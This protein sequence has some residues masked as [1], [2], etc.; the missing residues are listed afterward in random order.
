MKAFF[1]SSTFK[2]MQSERDILHERVFPKLRKVVKEYGD[3]VQEVD[4]RWG[5]D[6]VNMTEE[7]S[8]HEVLKIC[9]DAIDRCKPYLIVLLGERYGWIPGKDVVDSA[10]DMRISDR[11]EKEMSITEL[12]IQYGALLNDEAFK[13][14]IFCFRDA[15]VID[16]IDQ[17]QRYKY[18]A[19]SEHHA[20][21]LKALKNQ[22]RSREGAV[23]LDYT[24]DWDSESG[25]IC[26]LESFE[27][28]LYLLLEDMIRKDFADKKQRSLK[29][30]QSDEVELIKHEYLS[31]YVRR[32]PEEFKLMRII[33]KFIW[34]REVESATKDADCVIVKGVAGS[35]KS[36]LMA[37]VS[38]ETDKQKNTD[39]ILCFA[40]TS[41]CRNAQMLKRYIAFKLEEILELEH[42]ETPGSIDEHLRALSRKV[43]RKTIVC[44]VDGLDQIYA[45]E[46]EPYIDLPALCP[47]IFWVFSALP[48]FPFEKAAS[49]YRHKQ[50]EVEGLYPEQRESI[51]AHT[52]GKRGK[53]LDSEVVGMIAGRRG[54]DNPL[55]IS[56]VLQRF[57]MMNKKEFEEAEALAPGMEGLHRHMQKMLAEMPDMPD[58][59][60]GYILE[61]TAGLFDQQ[62][63]SEILMLIA[64]SKSG[65]T[66]NEIADLL[67]LENIRFSQIAFQ[68]TVSYLYDAFSQRSGGK[69]NF[70]HRLFGEAVVASMT[71]EDK[72]RIN[73]LFAL[74]SESDEDFMQREGFLY[75]LEQKAVAMSCVFERAATW[76][77]REEVFTEI[78]VLSRDSADYRHFFTEL[79]RNYPSDKMAEFWL[80]FEDF[81]YGDNAEKMTSEIIKTLLDAPLSDRYKWQLA[82]RSIYIS[83]TETMLDIL[84]KA[85]EY[86]ISLPEPEFSIANANI[87]AEIT[88]VLT[89]LKRTHEE[90]SEA[91]RKTVEFVDRADSFMS[92]C[93]ELKDYCKLFETMRLICRNALSFE[94]PDTVELWLHALK[95]TE[96][97][98]R[99]VGEDNYDYHKTLFLYSLSETYCKKPFRDFEK[100]KLYGEMAMELA[101]KL[102]EKSPT[103]RHLETRKNAIYA[104]VERLK[105]EYQY[106]YLEK[107]VDCAKRIYATQKTDYYKKELAYAEARYAFSAGK[108]INTRG[109]EYKNAF[110]DDVDRVWEHGSMLFEELLQSD[111]PKQYLGSYPAFLVDYAD[112]YLGRGYMEKAMCCVRRSIELL[113]EHCDSSVISEENDI[114]K[115]DDWYIAWL[116]R[117]HGTTAKVHLAR[118]EAEACEEHADEAVKLS[119]ER[120]KTMSYHFKRAIECSTM[121]AKAKYYQRKDDEALEACDFTESLISDPR[122]EKYDTEEYKAEINYIRARL[123]L[124]KGDTDKALELYSICESST[125][126]RY[127]YHDKLL[128]LKADCLTAKGDEEGQNAWLEALNAWRKR[129]NSEQA[130]FEDE[131]Y[132]MSEVKDK[133]VRYAYRRESREYALAA[134]YMTY[135]YY[136]C[137]RTEQLHNELSKNGDITVFELLALIGKGVLEDIRP[138]FIKVGNI[139]CSTTKEEHTLTGEFSDFSGFMDLLEGYFKDKKHINTAAYRLILD[140]AKLLE[141]VRPTAEQYGRIRDVIYMMID[142]LREERFAFKDAVKETENFKKAFPLQRDIPVFTRYVGRFEV[143]DEE[144]IKMRPVRWQAFLR[145]LLFSLQ[146]KDMDAKDKSDIRYHAKMAFRT[147][148]DMNGGTPNI[149]KKGIKAL[150]D[151]ELDALIDM[152]DLEYEF[153]CLPGTL[154]WFELKNFWSVEMYLRTGNEKYIS[155]RLA[156]FRELLTDKYKEMYEKFDISRKKSSAHEAA[157]AAQSL[158]RLMSENVS[159]EWGMHIAKWI[160]SIPELSAHM[161][162][163][164]LDIITAEREEDKKWL[165]DVKMSHYKK[166]LY[167]MTWNFTALLFT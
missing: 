26:G 87:Y 146:Y 14:C 15:A 144:R 80:A 157:R 81:A 3:E 67:E 48:D 40:A 133:I 120:A 25:S 12:E 85:K 91:R 34:D 45:G 18:T 53:K 52:A 27:E 104:Y 88:R 57:F 47:K 10:N 94:A 98:H 100:A 69:W 166:W 35:G 107:A 165:A 132:S 161:S 72:K 24:A 93:G 135:C 33:G 5:V 158:L 102:V 76:E 79:A 58:K 39:A 51:I 21:R 22:I 159:A 103:V 83:K 71:E 64:L 59:M 19:E 73:S 101:E 4:L 147:L 112:I 137:V 82:T 128:V 117:A 145:L 143:W 110:I 97:A 38:Q 121:A 150:S 141:G 9:I 156:E 7:E 106:P 155:N 55:F 77:N 119:L 149:I 96:S 139:L 129:L 28:R 74:Y 56:L 136:R 111:Y 130:R 99:F 60:A 125:F 17:S 6:T 108:A 134:Y 113:K 29:Q 124:E 16:K 126:N 131:K 32:Y 118:L 160:E 8:G 86:T 62:Q 65:L 114:K 115:Y 90:I 154:V 95:L 84:E 116:A 36:A 61:V 167:S 20:T 66:E 109:I 44:F 140:N 1:I 152:T 164:T 92:D 162:S 46:K 75:L 54:A 11:Y 122:A 37:Y 89:W 68:Q 49:Y 50:V 43:N 70:N 151:S 2:D 148:T 142:H 63:F 78:G 13:N 31:S 123:A 153:R 42:N 138:S 41:G 105:E 30:R 127:L 163:Q 23:I